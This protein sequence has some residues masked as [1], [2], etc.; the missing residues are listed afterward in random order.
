[1]VYTPEFTADNLADVVID[2]LVGT[3]AGL[4]AFVSLIALVLLWR[5]FSG[6]M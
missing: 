1:M 3:G 4:V 2:I 6:R 5:W